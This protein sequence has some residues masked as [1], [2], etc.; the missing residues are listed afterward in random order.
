MLTLTYRLKPGHPD[1][2]LEAVDAQYGMDTYS[3]QSPFGEPVKNATRTVWYQWAIRRSFTLGHDP[4]GRHTILWDIDDPALE[5]WFM[6][7]APEGATLTQ[8]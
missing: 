2:F 7:N 8:A 3:Y 5:L 4:H 1:P 6:L